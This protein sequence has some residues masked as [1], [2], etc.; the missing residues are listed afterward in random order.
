MVFVEG[1]TK[2]SASVLFCLAKDHLLVHPV[3]GIKG[4][5]GKGADVSFTLDISGKRQRGRWPR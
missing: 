1:N 4:V 2:L 5:I 3:L